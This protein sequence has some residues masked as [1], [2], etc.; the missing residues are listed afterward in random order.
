MSNNPRANNTTTTH[1]CA[2][3]KYQRRKCAPDCIL[4]PYFPHHRQRQFLNAHKLFG[5]SNISKTIKNIDDPCKKDQAMR[6]IIFQSDT[7]ANDPVGGCYRIICELKCQIEYNMVELELVLQQLAL[8]RAPPVPR[9][10]RMPLPD[11]AYESLAPA[12]CRD[13]IKPCLDVETCDPMSYDPRLQQRNE[14][15]EDYFLNQPSLQHVESWGM[16]DTAIS[17][18]HDR[19]S[20]GNECHDFKPTSVDVGGKRFELKFD[21]EHEDERI[22]IESDEAI[23]KDKKVIVKDEIA[24]FIENAGLAN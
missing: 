13:V 20:S 6:T 15:E 19:Q 23:S 4:A 10:P 11:H 7:R 12:D 9:Q 14:E 16:Q 1:A 5:V 8:C 2:A 18:L 3:C 22:D 17:S 24:A 21:Y